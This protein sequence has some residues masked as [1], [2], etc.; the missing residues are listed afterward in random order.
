[1]IVQGGLSILS[2]GLTL[3]QQPF[4]VGTLHA[5][6]T[7]G[8]LVDPL[9][10]AAVTNKR[11]AGHM[12]S[13]TA[14]VGAEK[15]S[16]LS[17]Q[18]GSAISSAGGSGDVQNS[19]AARSVA[20]EV[21]GSGH[22]D[23]AGGAVFRG[24]QGLEV[25][26]ASALKGRVSLHKVVLAPQLVTGDGTAKEGSLRVTVPTTV[27]YVVISKVDRA[28][29]TNAANGNVNTKQSVEVVFAPAEGSTSAA[30]GR[31]VLVSNLD[32]LTTSGA[33][34][35]PPLSTV[36]I[37]FDGQHWVSVDALKA[38]MHVSGNELFCFFSRVVC[39]LLFCVCVKPNQT[40]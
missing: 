4:A 38:P 32:E 21:Q 2:G 20:F 19:N 26:G 14:P 10:S 30:A 34:E 5:E 37:L 23:S 13:L 35:V 9:L 31:V 1:M 33:C 18:H 3:E 36:M 6:G 7:A 24:P 17:F 16:F 22:L 29:L 8:N 28:A 11:Y 25:H 27:T 15:L 12:L 40:E 39:I